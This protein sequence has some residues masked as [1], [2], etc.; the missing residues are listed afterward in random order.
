MDT[1]Y[2]EENGVYM[3]DCTAAIWSTN[4]IHEHYAQCVSGSFLNDVDFVIET[5]DYLLLVEYKNANIPGAAHPEKFRPER[6]EKLENVAKKYYDSLH[7]LFLA[8]KDKPKQFIYIVEYPKGDPTSRK[9]LRNKLKD[10]LPFKMQSALFENRRMIEDVQV[11]NIQE[12]NADKLFG[13][14][15]ISPVGGT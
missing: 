8:G 15:P 3:L 6:N 14:F 5:N 7:Y 11:L 12:W 10:R 2:I 4:Q 1:V 13:H 9:M